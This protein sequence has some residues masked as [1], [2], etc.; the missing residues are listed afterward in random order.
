MR[1]K[2]KSI[3]NP[4][5][6]KWLKHL[7]SVSRTIKKDFALNGKSLAILCSPDAVFPRR[8]DDETHGPTGR[9]YSLYTITRIANPRGKINIICKIYIELAHTE[10]TPHAYGFGGGVFCCMIV[11]GRSN[12]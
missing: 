9:S 12:D 6:N 10:K 4:I 2:Q 3:K 7:L 1:K 11:I 8:A 5:K